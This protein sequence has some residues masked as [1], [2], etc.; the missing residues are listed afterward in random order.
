M[1][2]VFFLLENWVRSMI[3]NNLQKAQEFWSKYCY[4]RLPGPAW[5]APALSP[6][7][8][9]FL[10][11]YVGCA[12]SCPDLP[13]W[14]LTTPWALQCLTCCCPGSPREPTG[15]PLAHQP[16]QVVPAGASRCP[17]RTR[18]SGRHQG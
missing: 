18:G 10:H 3:L 7:G 5:A 13:K 17:Q 2:S 11:F 8:I 9:Y 1:L 6:S 14:P 16:A 15:L 12:F 4:L